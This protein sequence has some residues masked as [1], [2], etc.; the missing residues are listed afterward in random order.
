MLGTWYSGNF[1]HLPS[2]HVVVHG[3]SVAEMQAKP[4]P[5]I[6]AIEGIG[7]AEYGVGFV[8]AT[9]VEEAPNQ[10]AH[11]FN[12]QPLI[13]HGSYDALWQAQMRADLKGVA[14]FD[15]L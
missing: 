15:P 13:Y 8:Q 4:P 14:L 10:R 5:C 9:G 12:G 3:L 11:P 6:K 1:P 2:E 7:Y